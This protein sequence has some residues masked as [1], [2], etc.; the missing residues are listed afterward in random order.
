M[1]MVIREGIWQLK[2]KS[3]EIRQRKKNGEK[4]AKRRG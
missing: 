2:L 1:G 3:I 4:N